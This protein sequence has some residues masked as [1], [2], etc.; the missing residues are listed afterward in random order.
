M[1]PLSPEQR[2]ALL[3]GP[4]GAPPAGQV[5][6]LADPSNLLEAGRAI[7]LVFW[8][9]PTI[10][11]VVRLYTKA[12]ILRSVR[13]SDFAMLIAWALYMG[14]MPTGWLMN[15]VSRG[16]DQWNLRLRD[17]I[18][19]LYYFHVDSIIYGI[20]IFFIKLSILL[21]FLEIFSQHQRDYFFWSCHC[22]IW[23]NFLFYAIS[24]FLE[25]FACHPFAKAWDV[26]ITRGDCPVDTNLLNVIA[27]SVNAAS[28]LIILVL[29][30]TRIWQLHLAVG[31]K[32][33][34]SAVF[35]VGLLASASAVVRLAYAV[36]LFTTTNNISY[37]GYMAGIWTLPEIA[38]GIIAGCL[39]SSAK[40]LQ[41]LSQSPLVLKWGST[42]QNLISSSSRQ[43]RGS[44]SGVCAKG[45]PQ[46]AVLANEH[47]AE[48]DQYPL[49][50]FATEPGTRR[51][52]SS[53]Q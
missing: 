50:S 17:F 51:S 5:P 39:P 42:L 40:F 4:A 14:Y 6:N 19:M 33:A 12:C 43:D 16:L 27:S 45:G 7:I 1:D 47:W 10:F 30:Q 35:S 34:I 37:F 2:Q 9:L 21:Q 24:T 48:P 26:L 11:L 23:V 29:P 3:D 18:S 53:F 46:S 32:I 31:K 52:L 38:C 28:D 8:I 49:T 25:I 15:N 20:C 22:L 13:I 36:L 41:T 44:E